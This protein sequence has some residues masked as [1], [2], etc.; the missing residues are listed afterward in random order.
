[1]HSSEPSDNTI[2]VS[3][4]A[5]ISKVGTYLNAGLNETKLLISKQ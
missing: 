3:D 1:M 5:N 2:I 4:I